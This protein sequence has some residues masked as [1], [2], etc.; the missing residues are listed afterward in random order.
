MTPLQKIK[1]GIET[2]NM[3]LVAEGYNSLSIDEIDYKPKAKQKTAEETRASWKQG[4]VERYS[5]EDY[6]EPASARVFS[7]DDEK[8]IA[9]AEPFIPKKRPNLWSDS[10]ETPPEYSKKDKAIDKKNK[11]KSITKRQ[12]YKPVNVVCYCCGKSFS[13]NPINAY[14]GKYRCDACSRQ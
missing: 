14:G 12:P 11:G 9:K 13:V 2:E 4:K 3:Q 5:K 7:G 6:S 10:G 1:K 8:K